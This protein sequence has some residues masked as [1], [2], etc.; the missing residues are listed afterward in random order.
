MWCSKAEIPQ[1]C[2]VHG[3]CDNIPIGSM[4]AIDGN[5]YH[6]YTTNVSI[7]IYI[8]YMDPTGYD[9]QWI[10][11]SSSTPISSIWSKKSVRS[12]ERDAMRPLK[13]SALLKLRLQTASCVA[14]LG[15]IKHPV[16]WLA[17]PIILSKSERWD[18]P[19]SMNIVL[20]QAPAS[21]SIASNKFHLYGERLPGCL[22]QCSHCP[23]ANP[24]QNLCGSHHFP[25]YTLGYPSRFE[26]QTLD[27]FGQIIYYISC[28]IFHTCPYN[29]NVP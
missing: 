9:N 16:Q 1:F 19:M 28:H 8:P 10:K 14:S 15:K 4:Y 11:L 26:G 22:K 23:V 2:Q 7:Y 5:I 18:H 24:H 27:I 13:K 25:H 3:K 20:F 29:Y 21:V 6:Q 17:E 12:L